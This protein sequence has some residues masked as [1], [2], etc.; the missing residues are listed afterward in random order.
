MTSRALAEAAAFRCCLLIPTYDNPK[1]I[2]AVVEAARKYIADVVV[3]DDGSAEPGRRACEQLAADG[4]AVVRHRAQNGGKGAA[5]KTGF[6]VARELGFSHVLQIDADGQH[7]TGAIPRFL[8]TGRSNPQALVV[9]Y[10]E[11]DDSIPNVR[12]FARE[13]TR[14]WVDLETGRG[15]IRDSM[16][17]FRVYPLGPLSHVRA[18]GNY[19]DFDIEVAVRMAWAGVRIINE[20]VKVRYLSAEEGG[21]S[22]FQMFWDNFRFS[23]LHSKLVTLK[24]TY[25]A[26]EK[27]GLRRRL[28]LPA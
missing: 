18:P 24:C 20:P 19:M 28:R 22:H 23:L 26:L 16:I 17:G 14:F 11:Y 13:F 10:P 6:E 4:L 12:R 21:V 5:V 27:L 25:W 1:T 15:V 8:E 9:G 7:D 3:V 2:R